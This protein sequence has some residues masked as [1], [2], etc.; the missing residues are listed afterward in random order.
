MSRSALAI[1]VLG[2]GIVGLGAVAAPGPARADQAAAKACADSLDPKARLVFDETAPKVKPGADV[3]DAL[4]SAVR[5]LVMG[6]KL[7]RDDA[8]AAAEAA[9][10]CLQKIGG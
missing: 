6:G 1:M 2:A 5:P 9:G 3:K 7:S 10:P 8:R 4:R